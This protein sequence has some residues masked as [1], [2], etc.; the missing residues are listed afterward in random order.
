MCFILEPAAQRWLAQFFCIL[1]W[2]DLLPSAKIV[3][4][5]AVGEIFSDL[6]AGKRCTS[7]SQMAAHSYSCI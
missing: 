7:I 4:L 5:R 6:L 2:I 1:S 3:K